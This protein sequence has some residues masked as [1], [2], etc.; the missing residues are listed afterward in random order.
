[1]RW[2]FDQ[3]GR[4][5]EKF[6]DRLAFVIEYANRT[7]EYRYANVLNQAS[8]VPVAVP[9]ET[10][11]VPVNASKYLSIANPEVSMA[12]SKFRWRIQGFLSAV[13]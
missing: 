11:A 2:V 13:R 7:E 10:P 3:I 5:T 6:P 12:N 4:W 8:W 9:T 1:V